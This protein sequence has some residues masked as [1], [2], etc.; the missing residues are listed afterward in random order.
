M[1]SSSEDTDLGHEMDDEV[2]EGKHSREV[3]EE[4][5]SSDEGEKV[6]EE[7]NKGESSGS[8]NPEKPRPKSANVRSARIPMAQTESIQGLDDVSS[9]INSLDDHVQAGLQEIRNSVA[10]LRHERK[11]LQ[12]RV[13]TLSD[14]VFH[15]S[16]GRDKYQQAVVE[17]Q[18]EIVSVR[19]QLGNQQQDNAALMKKMQEMQEK[20]ERHLQNIAGRTRNRN[21]A[22]SALQKWRRRVL[23]KSRNHTFQIQVLE[24]ENRHLRAE[25]LLCQE[26]AKQAFLR[27]ANA[28][29][30]EAITM[31]QDA[32]T[33]RLGLDE[34]LDE[35]HSFPQPPRSSHPSFHPQTTL[36]KGSHKDEKENAGSFEDKKDARRHEGGAQG[37]DKRSGGDSGH[38]QNISG[39]Q[40]QNDHRR[41]NLASYIGDD[42]EY[43]SS[44]INTSYQRGHHGQ[45]YSEDSLESCS[46]GSFRHPDRQQTSGYHGSFQQRTGPTRDRWEIPTDQRT[47]HG[48][49]PKRKPVISDFAPDSLRQE[50]RAYLQQLRDGRIVRVE[51]TVAPNLEPQWKAQRTLASRQDGAYT[52]LCHCGSLGIKSAGTPAPY[53][54]PYC[55]PIQNS[56]FGHLKDQKKPENIESLKMKQDVS[57]ITRSTILS[58]MNTEK[59]KVI[60][61]PSASTVVI[62]KYIS[63]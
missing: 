28:L 2:S 60:Y 46:S 51:P 18:Q 50:S 8:S 9:A 44:H 56:S 52:K 57:N 59:K 15:L 7:R 41:P 62:E 39:T 43:S 27:S 14:E 34:S 29:N 37:E 3:T 42:R 53:K 13:N 22:H 19:E 48:A 47:D 20:D 36:D 1:T 17:L 35:D 54:C 21:L 16:A 4:I 23:D 40:N 63:K 33:R 25:L 45:D 32:A 24:E 10:N 58:C 11:E 30:S 38:G 55:T 26:A 5:L 31:F 6:Q 49:V 61:K 12:N